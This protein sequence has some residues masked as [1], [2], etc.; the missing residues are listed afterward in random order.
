[1]EFD[2]IRGDKTNEKLEFYITSL[3]WRIYNSYDNHLN[4]S[5]HVFNMYAYFMYYRT[6]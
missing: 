6:D 5:P 2:K 1:M 3:F 4:I